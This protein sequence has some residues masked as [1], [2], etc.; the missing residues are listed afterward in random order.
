LIN[1][2]VIEG[3]KFTFVTKNILGK[4]PAQTEN[5]IDI[6]QIQGE[7][8]NS[9]Y[10]SGENLLEDILK[11]G[12]YKHQKQLQFLA[13]QHDRITLKIRFVL[14]PFSFVFLL[15]GEIQFHIVLETLDTEEATYIWHFTKDKQ[16]LKS[17]LKEID[18]HLE[19]IKN[20]GRQAFLANQPESFSRI[21][22]DYSED[23]KGFIIWKDLLEEQ[24]T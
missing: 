10:S 1:R 3:V 7:K 21:L 11:K 20:K 15:A 5:L 13:N 9:L 22:H 23:K 14:N 16:L 17:K 12:N 6:N 19:I 24:I 8:N 4:Q 2:E 18:E